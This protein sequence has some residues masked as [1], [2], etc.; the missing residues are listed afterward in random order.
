[1]PEP[2]TQP[3]VSFSS[4]D[5]SGERATGLER[6]AGVG[7]AGVF[8]LLGLGILIAPGL[9][10]R[11]FGL[12]RDDRASRPYIRALAFRDFGLAAI[13]GLSA[14]TSRGALRAAALGAATIPLLDATMVSRHRGARAAPSLLLHVASGLALLALAV[15]C[16]RDL[17]QPPRA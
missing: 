9:G 1:M 7:L 8:G 12:P 14:R 5:P 15:S 2:P 16:H 13:L 11:A 10:A 6:P 4:A 17:R 3:A